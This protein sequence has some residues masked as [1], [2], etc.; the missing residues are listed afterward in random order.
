VS[1]WLKAEIDVLLRRI[2]RRAERPLLKDGDPAATLERLMKERYP[3]YAEA[4]VTVYS[5]EVPHEAIVVEIV[6]AL[7]EKLGLPAHGARP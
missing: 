6:V 2:K 4:D 5:R 3:A 1:V 7:A